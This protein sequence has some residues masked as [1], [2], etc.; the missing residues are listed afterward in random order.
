MVSILICLPPPP[1][2]ARV[3]VDVCARISFSH[4]I[5]IVILV[6]VVMAVVK[7]G[8]EDFVAVAGVEPDD[9]G[10]GGRDV[11]EVI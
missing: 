8:V 11:Y 7:R 3:C 6:V 5:I 9:G 1:W 10:G 2:C 4:V